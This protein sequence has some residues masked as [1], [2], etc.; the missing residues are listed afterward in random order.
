MKIFT[1]REFKGHYPVGA[2]AVVVA[3]DSRSAAE[4]LSARLYRVGL[5]QTVRAA[6]MIELETDHSLVRILCDGNY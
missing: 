6:D 5:A 4:A 1:N 3:E 2:A